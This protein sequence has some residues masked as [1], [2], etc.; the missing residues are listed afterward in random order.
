MKLASCHDCAIIVSFEYAEDWRSGWV[1]DLL[2][3]D[4][5]YPCCL[6]LA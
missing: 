6:G 4:W 1:R 3:G 5:Y 2:L